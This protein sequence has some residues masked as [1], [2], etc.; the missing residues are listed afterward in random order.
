MKIVNPIIRAD[1]PDTDLL[2]VKDTY[3]MVSTTMFYIPGAP[4]L[5]SK[6]LCHWEIVSYIFDILE[7]NEIYRLEN[8]QNAYGNGQWATSLTIY[9][10]RYYACFAS[11]DGRKT[12]I[13]STDDIEKSNWE[14]T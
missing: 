2:R 8:G 14:R 9:K 5:K 7:D 12:Y 6:D 13:F 1:M 10:G 4:I 3:Y 11:N